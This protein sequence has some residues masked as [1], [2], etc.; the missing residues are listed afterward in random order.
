MLVPRS[1]FSAM[2]PNTPPVSGHGYEIDLVHLCVVG[3]LRTV[4]GY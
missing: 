2:L 3:D 1:T 4:Q